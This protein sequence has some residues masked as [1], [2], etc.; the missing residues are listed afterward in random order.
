[1]GSQKVNAR[2]IF[3]ERPCHL[4]HFG[5]SYQIASQR[6]ALLIVP[7]L[8]PGLSGSIA[9]SRL[10]S[11]LLYEVSVTDP[12]TF[13]AVSAGLIAVALLACWI[14]AMRAWLSPA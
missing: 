9:L 8:C 4:L 7:G 11:G 14:P 12:F 2:E 5:T 1:M 13:V 6:H 10:L 3:S